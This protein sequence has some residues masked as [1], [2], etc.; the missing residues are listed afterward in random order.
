MCCDFIVE[1]NL[2]KM[3]GIDGLSISDETGTQHV[4]WM[5]RVSNVTSDQ[6]MKKV[7]SKKKI[8]TTK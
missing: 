1:R 6:V 2:T 7:T 3:R 4:P 8:E 5:L